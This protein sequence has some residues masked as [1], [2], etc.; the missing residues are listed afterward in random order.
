[1]R[2]NQRYGDITI[3]TAGL[4]IPQRELSCLAHCG[5]CT[6]WPVTANNSTLAQLRSVRS[7]LN[8]T[9]Q[10]ESSNI[11]ARSWHAKQLTTYGYKYDENYESETTANL[12]WVRGN[13]TVQRPV[14]HTVVW[15]TNLGWN[16]TGPAIAGLGLVRSQDAFFVLNGILFRYSPEVLP[17]T[18]CV[19]PFVGG[20]LLLSRGLQYRRVH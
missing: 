9:T 3:T 19:F 10:L 2:Q 11:C 13:A 5:K 8:Y 17:V 14:E 15:A 18:A 20:L 16:L 7:I 1:M 4:T 6:R 12:D